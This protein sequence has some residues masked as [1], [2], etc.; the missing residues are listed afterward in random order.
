MMSTPLV[1]A[2]GIGVLALLCSVALR[3]PLQPVEDQWIA[4]SYALRGT[5]QPDTNIVLVYVDDAAIASL[6]WPVRRNFYALMIKALTDLRA[7]VIGIDVQFQEPSAEYPGYDNLLATVMSSAGNVVLPSY[8]KAIARPEHGGRF[9]AGHD[10]QLPLLMLRNAAA[11]IGHENLTEES[12][13]PLLV[14]GDS[15]LVPSFGAEV[16]RVFL[17]GT[18]NTAG[19][20]VSVV[21]PDGAE[22]PFPVSP[23]GTLRLQYP[24]QVSSFRAY[25]F[26]DVL[27]SYDA[28]R[29]D[30]SP[31][32]PVPS[33][34]GKIVLIGVISPG[35]TTF[36][37]TP[38]SP[39]YPG[40]AL[41]AVLLDNAL[42]RRFITDVPA[43]ILYLL[44]AVTCIVAAAALLLLR[45]PL[46]WLVGVGVFPA[47]VILS[48][49][50][51]L[52]AHVHLPVIP[53]I[54]AGLVT[55]GVSLGY[56]HR[57]V[58]EQVSHLKSERDAILADLRDREAKVALLE[59]E[60][61]DTSGTRSADRTGELLE[62]I[63]KYKAEIRS[64]SSR[65]DDME[66]YPGDE[67]ESAV[68]EFGGIV[69]AR[70][71][72]MKNVVDF[73][74][75]MAPSDAA[76]LILGESGT[77]KE[78]VARA[79]HQRSKR[80]Q[81]AFIAVNCGALAE[82]LLESELFGH[83]KG[84]F[85]GAVKDR[86]GRFE[87]ADGGTMFLDEIG[88]V[89][90]A[91]QVRLLRVLQEGEFER[92]GGTK[93]IHADVRVI[94]ATNKDL[95]EQ[96]KAKRFR[97]DLYYRLNVL[98]I[99]LPPLRERQEDIDLLVHHFLRREG[100]EI[101]VS[102]NVMQSLREYEWRGNIR[103]LESAVKRAVL[104][105]KAEHRS[106]I[107]MKDLTEELVAASQ[108]SVNL[109]DQILASLREKGFSRSSVSDT[110]DELGGMNRGT[111]AEYLRGQCL[112]AFVEGM[113]DIEKAVQ[114]ISLSAD[115]SINDRVRK[116][117]VDYLA[118][119]TD[120][121]D[122]DAT[123]ESVR[124]SLRPKTKNLPQRYHGHLE[125]AAEAFY[126]GVWKLPRND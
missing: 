125:S 111:V 16:L 28:L 21:R 53:L 83:E 76:V 43:A 44:V 86:L 87:L 99:S 3:S 51:F 68:E 46:N 10:L 42:Q 9:Y 89:S 50:L 67:G 45:S 91:F 66:A 4:A 106:M 112:R 65:A 24:G 119:L 15:S 1:R 13:I 81:K 49:I 123:W 79:L 36:F 2:S 116:R 107:T 5:V 90:E 52:T 109:E 27:R 47:G 88:E 98:S 77:G 115:P 70:G 20:A 82:N 59:R 19:G 61:T 62:E 38:V 122:P 41:H 75:K 18:I 103:E 12:A 7:A 64:L 25:P 92:V 14:A 85:T 126:R 113:Y 31:V 84:A 71:G 35:R 48:A 58:R 105:A 78:L 29:A 94:A 8:F 108:G 30:R 32:I 69:Y 57:T 60:L 11:G 23:D 110:A 124:G 34:R 33:F 121:I 54:T 104:L 120:A 39:R 40:L 80:A 26:L 63:R 93:T 56:K 17:G 118:N 95:K 74:G 114:H 100:G 117:I 55:A 73:I 96:V 72:K 22:T 102:K 101:G 37:S 97:E 6:G